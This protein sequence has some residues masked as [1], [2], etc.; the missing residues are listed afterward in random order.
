MITKADSAWFQAISAPLHLQ[1]VRIL[2]MRVLIATPLYPPEPGGPATYAKLLEEGLPRLGVEVTL[3]KFSE[4]RHLPKIVRHFAYKRRLMRA[5]RAADLILAL[6]PVSTGLP[7]ASAARSLGKPFVLKIV[8]DYA[9]EQGRQQFGVTMPLD[10]FV[11]TRSIPF[12]VRL[13]RRIETWVALRAKR[14]IVPSDY[15]KRVVSAWGIPAEKITVVHNAVAPANGGKAPDAVR[16]LPRPRIVTVARLVPWKRIDGLI[17]AVAAIRESGDGASLTV[18]GEGPERARLQGR[19]AEKLGDSY[20][21]TGTLAP[22]DAQAV[23]RESDIFALNSSYEGLSHVLIEA[24][25]YGMP[26]VATEAGGNREVLGDSG[27]LVPVDGTDELRDALAN[28]ARDPELRARLSDAAQKRTEAFSV[29]A[30]LARTK[31]LLETIV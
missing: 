18:V 21:F 23:L 2:T 31:E 30:M 12:Q 7:A 29:P 3:V 1:D 25:M 6:D 17:D 19:A 4:V 9:W 24:L 15:L 5:G 20:V 28:L 13:L 27:I 8:G 10:E 14:V 26:I 22:E 16:D 11:R